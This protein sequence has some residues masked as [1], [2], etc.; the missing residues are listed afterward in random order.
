M[1]ESDDDFVQLCRAEWKRMLPKD[2]TET[3]GKKLKSVS[4]NHTTKPK[5][6][7]NPLSRERK[8]INGNKFATKEEGSKSHQARLTLSIEGTASPPCNSLQ[9][10]ICQSAP[11]S[12]CEDV[13]GTKMF[14]NKDCLTASAQTSSSSVSIVTANKGETSK[15]IPRVKDLVLQNM[16]QFKRKK[17]VQYSNNQKQQ[18][19]EDNQS[20]HA[21]DTHADRDE[22]EIDSCQ[23]NIDSDASL[24]LAMQQDMTAEAAANVCPI[25]ENGFFFCVICQKDLSSMNSIRRAQHINRC[26]DDEEERRVSAP[27]V[28]ECPIC[29]KHFNT[30][31]SRATHLKRCAV[32]MEVPPQLLLQAVQRQNSNAFDSSAPLASLQPGKAKRKASGK[33]KEPSKKCKT[34]RNQPVDE[35]TMVAMALSASLLEQRNV[36]IQPHNTIKEVAATGLD[37]RSRRKRK[38]AV[39]PLLVVQDSEVALKHIQHRMAMLLSEQMDLAS[40]PPLPASR[41]C[42]DGILWQTWYLPSNQDTTRQ[43]SL[44]HCSA[45]FGDWDSTLYYTSDLVP[46]IIPW[47]PQ[48]EFQ[49]GERQ[50]VPSTM[51]SKDLLGLTS[52]TTRN[53]P[54]LS[55]A[56]GDIE[57][58]KG[59]MSR[60]QQ[61]HQALSDLMDLAG[62]GLTMTQWNDGMDGK[63]DSHA[64]EK[65]GSESTFDEITPS[66]FV[67]AQTERSSGNTPQ[68]M[69]SLRKLTADFGGM[70]N[71]PHLSDVQFQVDNGEVVYA[72]LFVL[73]ARSPQLVQTVHD[74]GFLVEEDA[75]PLTRRLLLPEVTAQAVCAF[76]QYLYTASATVT[77]NTLSEVRHLAVRFSVNELVR[78]CEACSPEDEDVRSQSGNNLCSEAED[79]KYGGRLENFQELLRSMWLDE[80]E[81]PAFEPR[82]IE[83]EDEEKVIEKVE[84]SE[85]EELYEFA[86]TQRRIE[87]DSFRGDIAQETEGPHPKTSILENEA[88]YGMRRESKQIM[89]EQ[90]IEWETVTNCESLVRERKQLSSECCLETEEMSQQQEVKAP[91]LENLHNHS[92][93]QD[94]VLDDSYD[95]L[96]SEPADVSLGSQHGVTVEGKPDNVTERCERIATNAQTSFSPSAK[97]SPNCSEKKLSPSCDLKSPFAAPYVC[98]LPI[99]GLSPPRKV[100]SQITPD[101]HLSSILAIEDAPKVAS[102]TL[103]H[104]SVDSNQQ[105][106]L[107]NAM[108]DCPRDLQEL[109]AYESPECSRG[110]LSSPLKSASVRAPCLDILSGHDLKTS[111]LENEANEN[112]YK[113]LSPIS[114]GSSFS[115]P[116]S[117]SNDIVL[118]IDSDEEMEVEKSYAS[119][120]SSL[121]TILLPFYD[122][123]GAGGSGMDR[124]PVCEHVSTTE[125]VKTSNFVILNEQNS[126]DDRSPSK[127]SD[128]TQNNCVLELPPNSVSEK[129][130]NYQKQD[131]ANKSELDLILSSESEHNNGDTTMETSWLVPAT[132]PPTRIRHSSTQTQNSQFLQNQSIIKSE[133]FENSIEDEMSLSQSVGAAQRAFKLATT[134]KSP[135]KVKGIG[136]MEDSLESSSFNR[137]LDVSLMSSPIPPTQYSNGCID[138]ETSLET[139]PSEQAKRPVGSLQCSEERQMADTSVIE[140]KDTEE[141]LPRGEPDASLLFIDEPPIPF[142][143]EYWKPDDYPQ[144]VEDESID[145]EGGRV[146]KRTNTAFHSSQHQTIDKELQPTTSTGIQS[147]TPLQGKPQP[148]ILFEFHDVNNGKK[149]ALSGGKH[150][151]VFDSKIW[152][153]WDEE[154]E[155]PEVLPSLSQRLPGI[156]KDITVTNKYGNMHQSPAINRM[157]T[158]LPVVP[159]TP[160]PPYSEMPTPNLKKELKRFGVR[161]LV[162][163]KMILKLKEI[164]KYTHQVIASGTDCNTEQGHT[165]TVTSACLTQPGPIPANKAKAASRN[166]LQ[167]VS[168]RTSQVKHISKTQKK[169]VS[170]AKSKTTS[171]SQS[172][173]NSKSKGKQ[174]VRDVHRAKVKSPIK[175][176]I[177]NEEVVSDR[178]QLSSSQGSSSSAAGSEDAFR[179]Q[180][181]SILELDGLATDSGDEE[182]DEIIPSQATGQADKVQVLRQYIQSNPE[183]YTKI[184]LY[185]PFE[186][187]ELHLQLKDNGIKVSRRQLIDF[188]DA[189]CITFTTA[190]ERKEKLQKQKR[191][192]GK[193]GRRKAR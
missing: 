125:P 130:F 121:N 29:G 41:F 87:R 13:A 46:P 68:H 103:P 88:D 73:Y 38:E 129:F 131:K 93:K 40:T 94:M 27:A 95:S 28:P 110:E 4:T 169:P 123:K 78:M 139:S 62:E 16:Q 152:D 44:W 176:A 181:Q 175:S 30:S 83:S 51:V 150:A 50:K 18:Q 166:Y 52:E 185:K 122:F 173:T 59:L 48:Q 177:H 155:L 193:R 178:D 17:P 81:K 3:G 182:D 75:A 43:G 71:N 148:R 141:E 111:I 7:G 143:Y 142:D 144:S 124:S 42:E 126:K 8:R 77:P 170:G 149:D 97:S 20:P 47:K 86:A 90:S 57:T 105:L 162:K 157:K 102:E 61:D 145:N 146:G 66:G 172:K 76:L 164:Y 183:F 158:Q 53:E 190:G 84:D 147:S 10:I 174:C 153:D 9:Q 180:Q 161:P 6:K 106:S 98:D 160:E 72:H 25:W 137:S 91:Q 14:A 55:G 82:S 151:S 186:L 12:T 191:G 23:H 192:A 15:A 188:L 32:R 133:L 85:L 34:T 60:S 128:E 120:S 115:A 171:T 69:Q 39:P 127:S 104:F 116:D 100:S 189:Q 79:G 56:R 134:S 156:E 163:R 31:N 135:E 108:F 136:G 21:S 11:T 63:P 70:V 112:D 101:K 89:K 168:M 1:D 165:H 159:I 22:G 24:A 132:P 2:G 184:L 154:E 140:V 58:E 67:P 74:D 54:D 179:S 64:K 167:P 187:A 45:L 107:K 65:D 138:L 113:Q 92:L 37:K 33:G 5:V 26:L 117:K 36:D 99:V 119:E 118:L 19:E 109:E 35:D 49:L 114:I 80:V 96:F